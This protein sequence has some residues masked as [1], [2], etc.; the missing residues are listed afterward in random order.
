M[1]YDIIALTISA[2]F[3][4]GC[5]YPFDIDTSS[6]D[7]TGGLVVEGDLLIGDVSTITLSTV[8]PLDG[9]NHTPRFYASIWAEDD[10]GGEYY[11][12]VK[13]PGR[14]FS[15]DLTNA[16]SDRRYRMHIHMDRVVAG[17]SNDYST[18]WL[19]V[20][21]APSFDGIDYTTDEDNLYL[22]ISL[23]D[24]DGS[25]C[26]RWDYVEN[27]EYHAP[28]H[29]SYVYDPQSDSVYRFEGVY[30]PL[31]W[32]W[33]SDHSTQAGIAI[34]KSTGGERIV[35][36]K[37]LTIP[38]SSL[39]IQYLYNIQVRARGISRECYDFL[40]AIQVNST[41]TGSLFIPDPSQV[42]GNIRSDTDPQEVVIGYIEASQ[43]VT[44]DF[45]VDGDHFKENL[46]V[47]KTFYPALGEDRT[48]KYFYDL[49][50]L[51]YDSYD[52]GLTVLWVDN[53]CVDCTHWGGSKVKPAFWP[54]DHQ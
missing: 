3:L 6:E 42:V 49:G 44:K 47:W 53:R 27:W 5:V 36:H 26:F 38:R 24:P 20:S 45:Y 9:E 10:Q 48:L 11:A 28:E 2:L 54:N 41:H 16:S 50:Y 22:R 7:N 25:G 13:E 43:V 15:L 14:S 12:S 51:P 18:P 29:A 46:R 37:F 32:C 23:S 19:T 35:D 21:K 8:Q 17:N 4:S 1:K 34:A 30:S 40:H 52:N 33:D 31:Y 39:K